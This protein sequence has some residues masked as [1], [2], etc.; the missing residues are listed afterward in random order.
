MKLRLF[1]FAGIAV[2]GVYTQVL[3]AQPYPSKPIR[4]IVPFS[5]GGGADVLTRLLARHLSETWASGFVID[6]RPG[7]DGAIGTELLARSAPD[8]YTVIM[9]TNAHTITPSQR[10]LPYDPVKDFTPV[11]LVASIPQLLL[12]HPS[13]PVKSIKD[14]VALAKAKPGALSFGSSGTGTSPYLTMELFKSMT[15]IQMVHIPYKG[16]S[17]AVI[18]LVG[19]HIQVMFG[20]TSTTLAHAKAGKL[21]AIAVSSPAR[22]AAAPDVPTVAEAGLPGFEASTWFGILAPARLP[23][24]LLQTLHG[25]ITKALLSSDVRNQ[26][27]TLGFNPIGNTPEAFAG[28]IRGDLVKWERVIRSLPPS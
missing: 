13:L 10:K 20:S 14:L 26:V 5:A 22:I 21:R 15:G 8:G 9:I 2:A 24:E 23:A 1:V 17:L 12:V 28:V 6:N 7:A 27:I 18:D 19:G 16:S 4:F 3:H 11:T 25:E